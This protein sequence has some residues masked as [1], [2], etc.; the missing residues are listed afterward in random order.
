VSIL[1]PLYTSLYTT[2]QGGTAL[3]SLLSST[4]AIY[5]KQAPDGATLPYV[6]FSHQGGGP[7]N[8]YS[9]RNE[10]SVVF[11][12]AYAASDPAA[13]AIDDAVDAL[14]TGKNISITGYSTFWSAREVDLDL[15]ETTQ[16]GQR[17]Y[18]AGGF[19]RIRA[20]K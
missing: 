18:M 16:S 3:T 1:N 19:Y 11:I 5:N 13:R 6:V 7:D 9:A 8:D 17:I 15:V 2:L 10:N 20:G 12:R 4:A 14:I